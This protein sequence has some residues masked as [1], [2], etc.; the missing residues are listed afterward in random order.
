[1]TVEQAARVLGIKEES[2]RKRISRGKLRARKGEDGRLFVYLDGAKTAR[3]ESA[4]ESVTDG[5]A[6]MSELRDRIADLREQVRAER[7]A[8][9]EARRLLAAAL[10]RI[11][12][13]LEAPQESPISPDSPGPRDTPT[14]ASEGPETPD[15]RSWWRR[16]FGFD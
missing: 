6:L 11:P 7:Q 9:A 14:D 16:Y 13:Q 10:E 5:D 2:V 3:D 12:P 8:H 1:M 4:D 15:T